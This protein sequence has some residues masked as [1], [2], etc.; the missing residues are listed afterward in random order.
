MTK[1]FIHDYVCIRF[2]IILMGRNIVQLLD[3]IERFV[4][5]GHLFC[6]DGVMLYV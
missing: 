4:D 6:R 3:F 1:V 5:I 2:H